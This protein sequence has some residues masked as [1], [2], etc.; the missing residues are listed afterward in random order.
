MRS[1]AI[2]LLR[3]STEGGVP[4]AERLMASVE[5]V[6]GGLSL[7]T[8]SSSLLHFSRP[9]PPAPLL[10][11]ASASLQSRRSPFE[12]AFEMLRFCGDMQTSGPL[13]SSD[14]EEDEVVEHA[15]V[16]VAAGGRG[17]SDVACGDMRDRC[18]DR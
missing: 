10:L 12:S 3:M 4:A 18:G 5:D 6:G 13:H 8:S 9:L 16:V 7:P 2:E 1:V 17:V 15:V 11:P 14:E